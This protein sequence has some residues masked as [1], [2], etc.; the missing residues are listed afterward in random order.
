MNLFDIL[1]IAILAYCLIRGIFRGVIK[2]ISSLIGVLGGFYAAYTY[3]HDVSKFF[4]KW[5]ASHYLNVLSFLLIFICVFLIISIIGTV[6]KYILKIVF[7]GWA[8][9]IFGAIF[10]ILKG[11]LISSILLIVF[12]A[13]LSGSIDTIKSSKASPYLVIFS[14]K[15]VMVTPKSLKNEYQIK[16]K[17]IKKAWKSS[18]QTEKSKILKT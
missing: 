14:D 16:I 5:V 2:E 1:V 12:V 6:I 9:R 4:E 11:T 3:Y 15:M 18:G 7:L 13:F 10:G 17:D 8:D